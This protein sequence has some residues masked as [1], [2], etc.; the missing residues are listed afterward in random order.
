[1]LVGSGY[2]RLERRG[3]LEPESIAAESR[4]HDPRAGHVLSGSPHA[5]L[6]ALEHEAH[7]RMTAGTPKGSDLVFLQRLNS[8]N[9]SI[10][11]AKAADHH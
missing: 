2:V 4:H 3:F 9:L 7:R 11:T 1:M 10:G 8:D 6:L 5:D